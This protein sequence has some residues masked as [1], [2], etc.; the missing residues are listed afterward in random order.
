MKLIKSEENQLEM[1]VSVFWR[2]LV[3]L[4][5]TTA[6]ESF[7]IFLFTQPLHDATKLKSQF[8][9]FKEYGCFFLNIFFSKIF[10][11]TFFIKYI[12]TNFHKTAVFYSVSLI[13][14]PRNKIPGLQKMEITSD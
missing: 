10:I 8:I 6:R 3:R 5:G 13:L 2:V 9:F 12:F 1:C 11:Y 14:K 4:S 7:S